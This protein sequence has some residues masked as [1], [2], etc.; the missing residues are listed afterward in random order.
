MENTE[1]TTVTVESL[2][3]SAT[4]ALSEHGRDRL[5]A[6][7]ASESRMFKLQQDRTYGLRTRDESEEAALVTLLSQRKKNKV[8]NTDE[9]RSLKSIQDGQTM[10]IASLLEY[11]KLPKVIQKIMS[12]VEIC[13]G[14]FQERTQYNRI[15]EGYMLTD[16][17]M[18][19]IEVYEDLIL[20]WYATAGTETDYSHL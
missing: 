18:D 13:G 8:E 9:D 16:K 17:D 6:R 10:Y 12:Y 19:S 3:V 14:L 2:V 20:D 15:P 5:L 1:N 4:K 7:L 11:A